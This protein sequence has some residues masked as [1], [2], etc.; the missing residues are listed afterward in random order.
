[1]NIPR[2]R[3]VDQCAAFFKENDPGTKIGKNAIR[4]MAN[5]Q[6]IPVQWIG[7]KLLIN[8]DALIEKLNCVPN[9]VPNPLGTKV[10]DGYGK[11]RKIDI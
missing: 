6:E 8:M 11:I 10:E 9:P 5:N 4:S 2:M 3:T 7:R 1:M